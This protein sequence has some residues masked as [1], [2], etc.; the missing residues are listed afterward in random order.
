MHQRFAIVVTILIVVGLLIGLNAVNYLQTPPPEESEVMPNR[1][2]YNSGPTGT[3]AL[4]DLLNEAHF[5]VMRWRES[6]QVLLSE[7]RARVTTFVVVGRT[8]L[9]FDEEEAK[10][11]LIWVGQGGRLV[12]IDRHPE[13]KLLPASGDWTTNVQVLGYPSTEIDPSNATE[14]T[15]GVKSLHPAQPTLLTEN[16]EAVKP[17]RFASIVKLAYA[18]TRPEIE[19]PDHDDS[20]PVSFEDETPPPP[21]QKTGETEAPVA[22]AP[23]VHLKDSRGA[24]LVDFPHG[25]GRIVVLSDPYLVANGGIA[26]EDNLQLALNTLGGSQGLIAFDEYHQGRAAT[27]NALATYFAGTPILALCGQLALVVLAI[28]WTRG[29]RFGRPLPLPQIDRRSSLEFVASMA[30]LQQ[31]SR[32]L[33]LAIENI[34]SRTRRVLTRYAGVD[35][36]SSRAE[37]AERVANRSSL[38]RQ[39]LEALMRECEE[40]IN[41]TAITERRSIELVKRL[42]Q[43]ESAL[44]LR[45]RSREV[46]QAAERI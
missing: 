16:V 25:A 27:H 3:R 26:L 5:K 33:D 1:S 31:R 19:S 43:T 44:G 8:L 36:H 45:M 17:S 32:A 7:N 2:T 20:E 29:R 40:T 39:Q 23:V 21:A 15:E 30:E 12:I 35:Y 13:V 11:L 46:R 9:P 22:N 14:M 28:V 24:V 6:P 37:I 41:G 34:Y 18:K 10:T 4:Y 42:R 38:N